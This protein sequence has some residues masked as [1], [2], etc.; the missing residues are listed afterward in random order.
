MALFQFSTSINTTISELAEKLIS[1]QEDGASISDIT[2]SSVNDITL[3]INDKYCNITYNMSLSSNANYYWFLCDSLG[4]ETLI[5]LCDSPN[6]NEN[7]YHT[8]LGSALFN[9]VYFLYNGKLVRNPQVDEPICSQFN[10]PNGLII[11]SDNNKNVLLTKC[12]FVNKALITNVGETEL[13]DTLYLSTNLSSAGFLAKVIS[14]EKE[15]VNIGRFFYLPNNNI[16]RGLSHYKKRTILKNAEIE[17][18]TE[19]YEDNKKI[20]D[21]KEENTFYKNIYNNIKIVPDGNMEMGYIDLDAGDR[22]LLTSKEPFYN[23]TI[24]LVAYDVGVES[25]KS[26]NYSN[27]YGFMHKIITSGITFKGDSDSKIIY[28]PEMFSLNKLYENY[29][30]DNNIWTSRE[31]GYALMNYNNNTYLYGSEYHRGANTFNYRLLTI[32]NEVYSIY[33]PDY[34]DAIWISKNIKPKKNIYVLKTPIIKNGKYSAFINNLKMEKPVSYSMDSYG[35]FFKGDYFLIIGNRKDYFPTEE[36]SYF[37]H[38]NAFNTPELKIDYFG[39][40][41]ESQSDEEIQKNIQYLAKKFKVNL[42]D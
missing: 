36:P 4:Y 13:S 29:Q 15:F 23:K 7:G 40:V 39:I 41:E 27:H 28:Y 35:S 21:R 25:L 10:I 3:L 37:N 16:V 11:D 32:N 24:Y 8:T 33:Q 9:A 2:I 17:L 42:D 18:W 34:Q 26:E 1:W 31:W 22:L 19:C 12:T 38:N 30:Y 14:L 20:Y 6:V 5:I